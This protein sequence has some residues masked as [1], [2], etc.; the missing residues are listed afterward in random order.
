[1]TGRK[2]E[3]TRVPVSRR[4]RL[5][6]LLLTAAFIAAAFGFAVAQLWAVAIACLL[7]GGTM[8][9]ASRQMIDRDRVRRRGR[10]GYEGRADPRD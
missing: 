6:Y 2:P 1:V 8:T 3:R 7:M 4:F 10:R 9:G 5:A